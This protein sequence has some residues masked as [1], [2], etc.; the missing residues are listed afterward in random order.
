GRLRTCFRARCCGQDCDRRPQQARRGRSRAREA[1][2]MAGD[3]PPDARRVSRGTA[4]RVAAVVVSHGNAAELERLLPTLAPNVD[5]LVV[6]ANIPGS[7][8]DVPDG[9]TLIANERPA[10]FGA[11]VN[12]G[13]AAT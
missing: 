4:M 3:G 2:L 12:R 6:V 5:E 9:A 10:G 1:L 7:V 8:R 13:V 11:N